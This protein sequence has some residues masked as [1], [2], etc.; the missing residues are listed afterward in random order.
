[1]SGRASPTATGSMWAVMSPA[2]WYATSVGD[3]PAGSAN[4]SSAN[5]SQ[6]AL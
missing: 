5:S 3:F 2:A 4:G 6:M 1:M